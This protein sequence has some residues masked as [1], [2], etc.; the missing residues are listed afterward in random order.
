MVGGG[1]LASHPGRV[2]MFQLALDHWVIGMP[3]SPTHTHTHTTCWQDIIQ[4]VQIWWGPYIPS[5][6]LWRTLVPYVNCPHPPF[7]PSLVSH[8]YTRHLVQ[9]STCLSRIPPIIWWWGGCIP[10]R[11]STHSHLKFAHLALGISC[12][13]GS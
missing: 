12:S 9:F 5:T 10:S 11:G 1:G 3:P 13:V 8:C 2:V 4:I 7:S 6:L